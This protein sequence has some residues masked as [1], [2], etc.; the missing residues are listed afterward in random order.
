MLF[1]LASARSADGGFGTVVV[2]VGASVVLVVVL[3]SSASS[4]RSPAQDER[5]PRTR[6]AAGR[7]RRSRVD[8][9]T[10]VNL[11]GP[12]AR[13]GSRH[14]DRCGPRGSAPP[15]RGGR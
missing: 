6:T 13:S 14:P 1:S 4:G 5:R 3:V 2:V 10:A 8:G 11:P 9:G 12:R 7:A 15:A